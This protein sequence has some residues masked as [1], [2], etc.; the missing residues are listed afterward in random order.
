MDFELTREQRMIRDMVRD[1]AETEVAPIADEVDRNDRFPKETFEKMGSLGLLGLPISEKYGGAGADTISYALA[2]E[3]I[4]KAC[5]GTGL[6]YAASVSLGAGPL[7]NFGTEKQKETFLVPIAKGDTLGSFGLTEP[8]AGSDAGGTK[9]T[10]V[11]KGDRYVI[12][13]E[14]CWITNASYA[15]AVTITA[16][17]GQKKN[18]KN[19][20][21]AFIVPTDSPGF[22]I[23]SPYEKMGV[24]GSNTTE[25]VLNDVEVPK[26]NIL[27]DPD[28]G[29]GQFLHTLDG[30]RISIGA[31]A[32]GIAE[33]AYQKALAYAN[34]RKQFGENIGK[35]QA[36][37]FKLADM[38]MEI[39]L[40]RTSVHKAAWLK[41]QNRPFKKEA[42]YAKLFSSEMAT[43]VCNQALQIHG[44]YGYMRE[45]GIERM[46]R[47]TKLMEIGEGTS[48]IQRMVIAR[49]IGCF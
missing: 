14:K 1:F 12:N 32:V 9:T 3:E 16:V 46:L 7:A 22:K 21:S 24:R 27:G 34:E 6:S 15:Q 28:K 31:L 23:T 10:A 19:I 39:D 26:E 29:F 4:G 38:A 25:L 20:I 41:D 18:G 47:D 11:L 48:E 17:N 13:G 44:G 40:A 37:Q 49:E 2:V 33:A 35:F 30:G 5:G 43:R 45:F 8:N 36:I 42:A